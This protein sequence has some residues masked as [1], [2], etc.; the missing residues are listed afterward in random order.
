MSDLNTVRTDV[1]IL[2]KDVSN[3]QGLL[4][5]LDIAI[6][7]IADAT[8]GISQIL[9]VLSLIHISEPTRPY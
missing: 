3:I 6:D 4:G 2:K 5:R 7:K 1:E 9:A 8:N